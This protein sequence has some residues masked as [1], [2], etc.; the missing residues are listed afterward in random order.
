MAAVAEAQ[1][2]LAGPKDMKLWP[3]A[4]LLSGC[5]SLPE[6]VTPVSDFDASRYLGTWYEIARLDHRFERGLEQ[7][8]A[9]YEARGENRIRVINRGLKTS[10]GEWKQAIGKAAFVETP[11]NGYLKVSFFGPFYAPYVIFDLDPDYRI[12]YV[13]SGEGTL[14]LLGRE[15]QISAEEKQ[16]FLATARQAGHPVEELIWVPQPSGPGGQD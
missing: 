4:L 13:T 10:T 9:T 5:V 6:G 7:V 8:T 1:Q 14:W 11:D 3:L 2:L 16:R 12:A 15:P